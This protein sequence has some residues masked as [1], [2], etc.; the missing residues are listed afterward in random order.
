MDTMRNGF[1]GLPYSTQRIWVAQQPSVVDPAQAINQAT[2]NAIMSEVT[3]NVSMLRRDMFAK[4]NDPR[5]DLDAECGYPITT[6]LSPDSYR[7]LYDREPIATRVVQL[8][9]KESWQVT[10]LVYEKEGSDEPT[11]FE[12]AWDALGKQL[13]GQSW[14]Q[15]EEG[16]AVWEHLRRADEL[17]GIGHFGIILLGIDDGKNL[18]EPIEGILT[19]A[20]PDCYLLPTEE[21]RLLGMGTQN[22]LVNGEPPL[23]GRPLN[24]YEKS[25]VNRWARQREIL[26]N[27]GSDDGQSRDLTLT[28]SPESHA[29]TMGT[30]IDVREPSATTAKTAKGDDPMAAPIGSSLS[31]TDQQYFGVQF[32]APEKLSEKP[33]AAGK[34]K[35]L[36]IRAF[37]ESLVQIVRYEWNS[38]NPRFGLPV[39]YRVTLNDPREVHSGVGLPLATVF[40]HWSRLIHLA[41]NLGASEIFGVPRMRPVLN[42]LLD[43]RKIRAAGAE[44]YWRS[45]I[46]MLSLET[47]PQLGGD[48]Y[49]DQTKMKNLMENIQNGMQRI[50]QLT[51]LSAK[52]VA[53]SVVDPTPHIAIQEE[54]ICVQLG[55][56]IRVFKGSERGELASSQDDSSWNDRLR[57]RQNGYITPRIISPFIDRLIQIGVLP[58]PKAKPEK[59]EEFKLPETGLTGQPTAPPDFKAKP[60]A[61]S[62]GAGAPPPKVPPDKPFGMAKPPSGKAPQPQPA[63]EKSPKPTGNTDRGIYRYQFAFNDDGTVKGIDKKKVGETTDTG[64][65]VEWPDLDSLGKKDKAAIG[66]QLTQAIAAYVAGNCEAVVPILEY[67]TKILGMDEEEAKAIIHSATKQAEAKQSDHADLAQEHGM[68]PSPPPGFE[69][70][71]PPPPPIPGTPGTPPVKVKPGEKLMYPPKPPAHAAPKPPQPAPAANANAELLASIGKIVD[72]LNDGMGYGKAWYNPDTKV[73]WVS[74][75]DWDEDSQRYKAA[76]AGKAGVS[77]VRI[78]AEYDPTTKKHD[79]ENWIPVGKQVSNFEGQERDTHGRFGS[80]GALTTEQIKERGKE[81]IHS[82]EFKAW[83]GDWENNSASA[84][85]VVDASGKPAETV[86]VDDRGGPIVAFSGSKAAFDAFDEGKAADDTLYGKGFYFTEGQEIAEAYM[87]KDWKGAEQGGATK[88]AGPGGKLFQCYLRIKNPFDMEK[89]I[90]QDIMDKADAFFKPGFG[91]HIRV[92]FTED[93]GNGESSAGS[94]AHMKTYD[95]GDKSRQTD[96]DKMPVGGDLMEAVRRLDPY[97]GSKQMTEF[98]RSLGHDGVVRKD[99]FKPGAGRLE[100]KNYRTWVA[101]DPAQIKSVENKG[102]FST[103]D[104]NIYNRVQFIANSLS[105][106]V[107]PAVNTRNYLAYSTVE[108]PLATAQ[109]AAAVVGQVILMV[110]ES[111]PQ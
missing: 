62:G 90:S 55:C 75:G 94:G 78:E 6:T 41:D 53:P 12:Q 70:K 63:Q 74:I 99:A 26:F 11:P 39:M 68:V 72:R 45:C 88:D 65:S 13:R 103:K 50:W 84:S 79:G 43:L 8:M 27:V 38:R 23:K 21:E 33:A 91:K 34:R 35:L 96:W 30:K 77:L 58:E 44:G 9:P 22:I 46:T 7:D 18:E 97:A 76:L 56:P 102:T 14:Y 110:S 17:S 3:A 16:S 51:G 28:V 101:F 40:V 25:V 15:D 85:K 89:E 104:T 47:L 61:A 83:F 64:Y 1:N 86:H 80:G 42:P 108:N 4:F 87:T 2:V 24:D 82:P 98:L 60:G 107:P 20:A 100:G 10:P 105:K 57:H 111:L 36:F 92:P 37:D 71:P 95:N 81:Q 73:V 19:N 106:G 69:Q 52:T 54:A 93:D 31:G 5:R 59:K 109:A 49:I 48:V 67:M 66:L 29:P 32:G